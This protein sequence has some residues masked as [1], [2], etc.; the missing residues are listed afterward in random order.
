MKLTLWALLFQRRKLRVSL[1]KRLVQ[2]RQ[3]AS[4]G[5]GIHTL[6]L[7]F[8]KKAECYREGAPPEDPTLVCPILYSFT[9]RSMDPSSSSEAFLLSTNPWGITLGFSTWYLSGEG[10]NSHAVS[11]ISKLAAWK[12]VHAVIPWSMAWPLSQGIDF[13]YRCHSK[14]IDVSDRRLWGLNVSVVWGFRGG[15]VYRNEDTK[16]FLFFQ[17]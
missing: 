7:T 11:V 3:L 2:D 13:F 9:S 8:L 12:L 15:G 16:L 5:A 6:K 10:N 17:A 1:A 14:Q 4:G